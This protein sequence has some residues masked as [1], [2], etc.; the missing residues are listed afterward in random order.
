MHDFVGSSL[1]TAVLPR[2]PWLPDSTWAK[3]SFLRRQRDVWARLP[4]R[5]FTGH[6]WMCFRALYRLIVSDVL[7]QPGRLD[8]DNKEHVHAALGIGEKFKIR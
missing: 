8:D 4:F 3:S 1:L 7:R 6:T 2:V 5:F